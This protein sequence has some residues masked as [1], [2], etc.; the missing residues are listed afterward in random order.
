MASNCVANIIA[1]LGDDPARPGIRDTPE[2]FLRAL[3]EL[4]YGLREP[5]PQV[6]L[7]PM[8]YGATPSLVVIENIRAVGLCEH[9][10]LP[11]IMSV[12]VAYRPKGPVPGLSKVSRLVKWAAA[13]L[14]LQERF[15]EWLADLLMEKLSA[16]AVKVRVCG[17]H[18]CSAIRGVKDEHH[19]MVTEAVRGEINVELKCRRPRL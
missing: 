14:L 1:E 18:L 19:Y 12:S 3:R 7:F 4:T 11:I 13:R 15:T 8:E 10:L 2:R 16:E 5:P 17:V 9:H 6:V